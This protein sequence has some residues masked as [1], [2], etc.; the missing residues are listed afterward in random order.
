MTLAEIQVDGKVARIEKVRHWTLLILHRVPKP[1]A[2][3]YD[4]GVHVNDRVSTRAVEKDF[5]LFATHTPPAITRRE[6]P[7]FDFE[8]TYNWKGKQGAVMQIWAA[9]FLLEGYE[10]VGG[11]DVIDAVKAR[12]PDADPRIAG[13]GSRGLFKLGLIHRQGTRKSPR[14]ENHHY[15]NEQLWKWTA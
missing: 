11:S 6:V 4:P 9:K 14:V 3:D 13:L 5:W 2:F 15:P 8:Q 7:N 1:L 12:F 10:L